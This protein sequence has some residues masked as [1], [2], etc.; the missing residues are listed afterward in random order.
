EDIGVDPPPAAAARFRSGRPPGPAVFTDMDHLRQ[1]MRGIR[2][3]ADDHWIRVQAERL[4]APSTDGGVRI[5]Y[6]FVPPDGRDFATEDLWPA[7]PRVTCPVLI[8]RGEDSQILDA[9]QAA[10]MVATFPHAR[11]VVIRRAGHM[12]HEDNPEA[13]IA[14]LRDFFDRAHRPR[15]PLGSRPTPDGVNHAAVGRS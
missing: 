6:T 15:R 10:R 4:R 5:K 1:W 13:V 3:Y 2:P 11:E 9:A 12:T 8:I 7:L 14:A